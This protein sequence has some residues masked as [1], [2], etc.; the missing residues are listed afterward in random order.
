MVNIVNM[1]VSQQAY[2]TSSTRSRQPVTGC[3]I[4]CR[5]AEIDQAQLSRWVNGQTEPL[6]STVIRLEEAANALISARLQVLNKAM[7]DAVK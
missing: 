3:R 1:K 4:L 6:Y 2:T 7:E 5:V